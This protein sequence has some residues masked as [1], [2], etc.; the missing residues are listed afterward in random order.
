MYELIRPSPNA[1]LIP[2]LTF[3]PQGA[4]FRYHLYPLCEVTKDFVHGERAG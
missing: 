1:L 3:G 2:G 4:L